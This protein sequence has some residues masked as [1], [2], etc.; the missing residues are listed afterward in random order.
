MAVLETI[1]SLIGLTAIGAFIAARAVIIT[2]KQAEM[3]SSP[4][5]GGNKALRDALL[6]Q[7]RSAIRG[8]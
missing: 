7:S 8:L 2:D 5:W 6:A 3:L 4:Y 1:L